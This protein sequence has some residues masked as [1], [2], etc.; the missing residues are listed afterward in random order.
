MS[1]HQGVSGTDDDRNIHKQVSPEFFDLVMSEVN[2]SC[3][4]ASRRRS[5]ELRSVQTAP[6]P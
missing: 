5:E 6:D 1:L 3:G 2:R 4:M